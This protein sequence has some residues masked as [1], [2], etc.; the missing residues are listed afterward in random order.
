MFVPR[1]ILSRSHRFPSVAR[2]FFSGDGTGIA[3]QVAKLI[4]EDPVV[5]F[6]KSSC[7]FCQQ[8]KALFD[9]IRVTYNNLELDQRDDGNEIQEEL[10]RRTGQNTVPNVFIGGQSI[11]GWTQTK[12]LFD[13]GELYKKL[14]QAKG[15]RPN[16][17]M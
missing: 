13:S 6:S 2:R 15:L 4:K 5:I 9:Q 7:P 1:T 3:K 8:T 10:H 12:S 11:G 17:A 16:Y 14:D